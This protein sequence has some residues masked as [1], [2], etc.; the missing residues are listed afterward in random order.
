VQRIA[1]I[2]DIQQAGSYRRAVTLAASGLLDDVAG[3]AA[4]LHA[5]LCT[6]PPATRLR[7]AE[8]FSQLD[9]ATSLRQLTVLPG[10]GDERLG[11]DNIA[12]R[13]MQRMADWLFAQVVNEAPAQDA[14]NDLVRVCVLLASHAPVKRILSARIRRP[15]PAIVGARLDI[16]LDPQV[17]R[18]GMQVLVHAP[19]TQDILA[20]AVV[21]DLGSDMASARI[22][23]TRVGTSVTLDSSMRVQIQ[24]G[25]ALSTPAVQRSEAARAQADAMPVQSAAKVAASPAQPVTQQAAEKRVAK[26][27]DALRQGAARAAR[28]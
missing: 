2:R 18:I 8:L 23:Y 22:T 5:A 10:F 24:S 11:V 13:Q 6:V 3:V 26:Q 17:V 7:W 21:D 25:P 9:E 1:T 19:G 14:I 16:A 27:V 4:C 15:V 28:R 12:W 20:R